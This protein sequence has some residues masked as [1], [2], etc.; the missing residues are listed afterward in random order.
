MEP[1]IF[2]FR[3][4]VLVPWRF[5]PAGAAV[6]PHAGAAGKKV[7]GVLGLGSLT[8]DTADAAV[9]LGL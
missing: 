5:S 6:I 3:G 4:V 8:L 2:F 7:E 1:P 9:S